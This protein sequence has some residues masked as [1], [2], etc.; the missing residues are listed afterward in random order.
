ME[1]PY[2]KPPDYSQASGNHVPTAS[3]AM[4]T[5]PPTVTTGTD[6]NKQTGDGEGRENSTVVTGGEQN[7]TECDV[8][9]CNASNS[10]TGFIDILYKNKKLPWNSCEKKLIYKL[11][12]LFYYTANVVYSIAAIVMQKDHIAFHVTRIIMSSL[13]LVVEIVMM[14]AHGKKLC[15]LDNNMEEEKGLLKST[16]AHTNKMPVDKTARVQEF[17]RKAGRVILDYVLSSL[18][19]FLIYPI[20]ICTLYGFINERAWELNDAISICNFAFLLYS[21]IMELLYMNV[22]VIFHVI[23]VARAAYVKYDELVQPTEMEWKRYF[24]PVYMTIALAI[25]TVVTH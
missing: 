11:G 4:A 7:T 17:R 14:V 5:A 8:G 22:C 6:A 24:T 19:E 20:L 25:L 12:L 15:I 3:A 10:F 23:R 1:E 16:D 13:G 9:K 18:G 21:V 2:E